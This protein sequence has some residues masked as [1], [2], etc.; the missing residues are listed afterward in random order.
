MLIH[1]K[2]PSR[3]Q[4]R[5][6]ASKH[7]IGVRYRAQDLYAQYSI[8]TTKRYTMLLEL[9]NIFNATR[10]NLIDIDKPTRL[11]ILSQRLVQINIRFNAVD[12]RDFRNIVSRQLTTDART[13]LED[14]SRGFSDQVRD[15]GLSVSIRKCGT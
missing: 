5:V 2:L 15:S 14:D 9:H 7:L 8:N 3:F 13:E 10:D 11:N 4:Q 1:N 12:L 6:Q